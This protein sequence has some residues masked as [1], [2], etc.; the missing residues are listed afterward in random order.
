MSREGLQDRSLFLQKEKQLRHNKS[1]Q[2]WS[3]WNSK[4]H[5]W[6]KDNTAHHPKKTIHTLKHHGCS[7]MPWGCFSSDETGA[8]DRVVW[9]GGI[10]NSS[11][12]QSILAQALQVSARKLKMKH[13]TFQHDS[14]PNHTSKLTKEWPQPEQMFWKVLEWSTHCPKLNPIESLWCDLKRAVHSS[15][16]TTD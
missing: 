16:S 9:G 13:L 2:G 15:Q 5:A 7:I 14:N 10:I 12:Y 1:H 3:F 8:I 11:K 4:R 6:C